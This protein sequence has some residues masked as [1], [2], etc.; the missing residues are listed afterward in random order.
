VEFLG[1]IK[2]FRAQLDYYFMLFM[3]A[4]VQAWFVDVF[5]RLKMKNKEVFKV[6]VR[7]VSDM[8]RET[9]VEKIDVLKVRDWDGW[10]G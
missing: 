7:T 2:G 1:R 4:R 3:P 10:V 5:T 8:I 6:P 9:K